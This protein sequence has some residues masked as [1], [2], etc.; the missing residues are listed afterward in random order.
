MRLTALVPLL[1]LLGVLGLVAAAGW[2]RGGSD[3][4]AGSAGPG[5][6]P[7][8]ASDGGVSVTTTGSRPSGLWRGKQGVRYERS[9][10]ICSVFTVKEVA[11]E[12]GVPARRKQAALA[13]ANAWYDPPFRQAAYRGCL[14]AFRGRPPALG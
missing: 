4:A 8:A 12:L 2:A 1:W 14:D 5:S 6:G 7:V 3:E 13:H 9:Y 11:R 10:R